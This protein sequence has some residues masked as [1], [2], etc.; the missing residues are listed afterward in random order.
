LTEYNYLLE[1][2]WYLRIWRFMS[3][4]KMFCTNW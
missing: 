4:G 1:Y 2:S 3:S